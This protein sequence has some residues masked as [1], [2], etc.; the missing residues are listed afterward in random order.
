MND[1]EGDGNGISV[2]VM[3]II[4]DD[5]E[6]HAG[7]PAE[8]RQMPGVDARVQRLKLGDYLVDNQCLFE[9]KTLPDFAASIIDGRLFDQSW[10]IIRSGSL[11][12][13]ILEGR[14]K[15][16]EGIHI[17]RQA[18]QGAL[19]SLSLIYRLPVLRSF[20]FVETAHLIVYAGNQ[21]MRHRRFGAAGY[22]GW[23]RPKT[24]RRRQLHLLQ[25]LPGLGPDRA[26]RLLDSFG[27]V[28]AVM[29]ADAD[30]LQAVAGIGPK[31][32]QGIRDVLREEPRR[33]KGDLAKQ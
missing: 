5:R 20:D 28:E 14:G 22:H 3:E 19:V 21:M 8:L 2:P 30:A 12:A 15:D 13:L 23:G 29:T 31:I 26:A 24:K 27:T 6:C 4:V 16:L 18:L 10:R 25:A 17:T 1:A 7:V 9:R 11:S 33:W 32:A